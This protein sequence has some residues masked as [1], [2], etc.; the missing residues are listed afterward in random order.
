MAHHE[1]RDW[2]EVGR[3]VGAYGVKGW[4]KLLS[5]TAEPHKILTYQPWRFRRKSGEIEN[6]DVCDTKAYGDGFIIHLA[7]C[8]SRELAEP[9]TGT[10]I[11]VPATVLPPLEPGEYYWAQLIG[12]AVETADGRALGHVKELLGTGAND[13]LVV[14]GDRERLI[15]YIPTVIQRVEA[16]QGRIVVDWDPDF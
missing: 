6:P 4:L 16:D 14:D 12:L 7:G 2:I 5:Y 9:W 10:H 1:T 15:P 13:V 8:D 11:E 3:I